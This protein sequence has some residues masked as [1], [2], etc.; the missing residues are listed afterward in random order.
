MKLFKK[1]IIFRREFV[2]HFIMLQSKKIKKAENQSFLN[3]FSTGLDSFGQGYRS[4]PEAIDLGSHHVK[5]FVFCD[6][7]IVHYFFLH[8][9]PEDSVHYLSIDVR[10]FGY[11]GKELKNVVY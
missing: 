4:A 5:F 9:V 3:I 1:L 2:I 8:L 10:I 6:A 11:R 7:L